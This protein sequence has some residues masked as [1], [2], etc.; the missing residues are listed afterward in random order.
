MGINLLAPVVAFIVGFCLGLLVVLIRTWRL[1][2]WQS[3][4]RTEFKPGLQGTQLLE[5]LEKLLGDV[6]SWLNSTDI[7]LLKEIRGN[8]WQQIYYLKI[9]KLSCL[10]IFSSDIEQ[11]RFALRQ[12][13]Q[14]RGDEPREAIKAIAMNP[15]TE[16]VVRNE[17]NQLLIDVSEKPEAINISGM[18]TKK[19]ADASKETNRKQKTLLRETDD[20]SRN[21]SGYT[22]IIGQAGAVGPDA[23]AHD[24]TFNQVGDQSAAKIDLPTLARELALLRTALKKGNCSL[25]VPA[26]LGV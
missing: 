2:P 12:L 26:R 23:H 1:N 24:M 11:K 5:L 10:A 6:H 25:D 8:L 22:F 15:A 18:T 9:E 17:A 3:P 20:K 16:D 14:M 7:G 19:P 4:W 21:K 13:S